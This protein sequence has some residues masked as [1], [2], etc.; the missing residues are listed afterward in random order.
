MRLAFGW[1]EL[2]RRS[3]GQAATFASTTKEHLRV[4]K[5]PIAEKEWLPLTRDAR[6]W[7]KRMS[8]KKHEVA[9]QRKNV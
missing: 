4:L 7:N 6:A 8:T 2:K 3:G 5:I 1:V 9:A